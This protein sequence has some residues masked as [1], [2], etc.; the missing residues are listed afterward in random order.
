MS[1]ATNNKH[2]PSAS[3]HSSV[4]VKIMSAEFMELLLNNSKFHGCGKT[5]L[6][7]QKMNSMSCICLLKFGT[8]AAIQ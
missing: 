5:S 1:F 4:K 3:N 2:F 7:S 6:Y 8:D